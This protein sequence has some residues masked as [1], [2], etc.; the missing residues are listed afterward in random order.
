MNAERT[1]HL[2]DA[3]R[4]TINSMPEIIPFLESFDL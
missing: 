1:V 4:G 3:M 2:T